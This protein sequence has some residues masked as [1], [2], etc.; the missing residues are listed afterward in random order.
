MAHL[1]CAVFLA[2]SVILCSAHDDDTDLLVL[3]TAYQLRKEI[4]KQVNE[5]LTETLPQLCTS[6]SQNRS[7][8]CNCENIISAIEELEVY[9]KNGVPIAVHNTVSELLNPLL[10][11][12]SHLLVP[13]LTPSHPATCC[14]EIF[15]VDPHSTSGFYWIRGKK[16]GCKTQVL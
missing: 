7:S 16:R 5:A 8:I 1:V 9:I 6:D 4:R 15:K 10:S 11:Q 13:G 3:T 14:K 2:F 12:L